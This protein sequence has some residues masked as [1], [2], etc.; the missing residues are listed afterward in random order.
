M[1]ISID[2]K[3][4]EEIIKVIN[5]SIK[6]NKLFADDLK[7][8]LEETEGYK[9]FFKFYKWEGFKEKYIDMIKKVV[10]GKKYNT[11]SKVLKRM[12]AAY[13]NAVKNPKLFYEKLKIVKSIDIYSLQNRLEECLPC[14]TKIQSNLYF[15]LDGFNL[16]S[17]IDKHTICLDVMGWSI[18]KDVS[19]KMENILLHELHHIGAIYWSE[20]D[21]KREFLIKRENG[22]GLAVDL[23]DSILSE[24]TAFY[25]FYDNMDVYDIN[26]EIY[27]E[28]FTEKFE[29]SYL[30]SKDDIKEKIGELD[31]FL[32][33]LIESDLDNYN[34][35]KM[36]LY[37]YTCEKDNKEALDK[38]IGSHMC[39]FI[40][41]AFGKKEILNCIE[42]LYIFPIR[43]NEACFKLKN[44]ERLSEKLLCKWK[45]IWDK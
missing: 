12:S 40:E 16:G 34:E 39:R 36:K 10:E 43:Y 17:I 27:G 25:F 42:N 41:E 26:R 6:S 11:D 38:I 1:D 29:K 13:E 19:R 3:G 33:T 22:V 20:K 21:V 28:E 23:F 31:N 4:A 35:L 24:G 8:V 44:E 30:K 32:I 18:E 14:D 37:N 45:N 5:D 9:M 2:Y 15:I 7:L